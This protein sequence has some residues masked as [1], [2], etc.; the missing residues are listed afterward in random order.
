MAAT[1]SNH[2]RY[3]LATKKIDF[4]NDVFLAIILDDTFVFDPDTHATLP[5][6]TAKQLATG[7]G[8]TQNNKTLTGVSV[9]EDDSI[10]R[11]KITWADPT[12]AASGGEIG[13][14]QSVAIV[15]D[16]TTDDT[17]VGCITNDLVITVPD[18]K[19]FTVTDIEVQI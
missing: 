6:I 4:A 5:D 14:L 11:C 15:D 12:W 19:S 7:N 9:S 18:G 16:T 8:Y 3:M 10:N 1:L 2:F 13:P 17:V